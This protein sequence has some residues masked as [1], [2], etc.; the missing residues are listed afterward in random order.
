VRLRD[1]LT[2]TTRTQTGT[3][4]GGDPIYEDTETDVPAYVWWD[5]SDLSVNSTGSFVRDELRAIIGPKDV[6]LTAGVDRATWQGTSYKITG[7][8]DRVLGGRLQHVTL[9]LENIV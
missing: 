4:A 3:D 2:I 6:A 5:S 8:L 7:R 9:I 1:H